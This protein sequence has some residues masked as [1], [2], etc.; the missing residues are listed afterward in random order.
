MRQALETDAESLHHLSDAEAIGA[1]VDQFSDVHAVLLVEPPC[2]RS[3]FYSAC[4]SIARGLIKRHAFTM[5]AVE[6]DWAD[7]AGIIVYGAETH[8]SGLQA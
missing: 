6:A 3:A 2:G 8:P 5:V 4:A 7:T 1:L